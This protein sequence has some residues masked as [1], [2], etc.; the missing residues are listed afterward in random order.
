MALNW[1]RRGV[2][3]LAAGDEQGCRAGIIDV[4]A[5][6]ICGG[7]LV[8][9]RGAQFL[10]EDGDCRG[11]FET[12]ADLISTNRDNRDP[13]VVANEDLLINLSAQD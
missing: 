12:E 1:M 11:S 10:A 6:R 5:G 8:M 2:S 7:R 13:D 4:A 9:D 3:T